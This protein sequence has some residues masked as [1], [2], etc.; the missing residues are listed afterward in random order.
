MSATIGQKVKFFRTHRKMSQF[1]LELAID[2]SNGS[3]SRIEND[4]TNPTK[5]TLLDICN[6]LELNEKEKDYVIGIIDKPASDLE[7]QKARAEVKELM[8]REGELAYVIDD[9]GRLIDITNTFLQLLGIPK[10]IKSTFLNTPLL[11]IMFDERFGIMDFV[12]N[13]EPMLTNFLSRFHADTYF[14]VGDEIIQKQ[15]DL[16]NNN[17]LMK[18]I[19][20]QVSNNNLIRFE[21]TRNRGVVFEFLGKQVSLTYSTELLLKYRRFELIQYTPTTELSEILTKIN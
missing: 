9:R 11:C 15:R 8:E 6:V 19:W 14:F 18:E 12:I 2:A 17:L 1:D 10:E 3:I 13:P 7:V 5:E 21:D 4:Q 16:M 20:D